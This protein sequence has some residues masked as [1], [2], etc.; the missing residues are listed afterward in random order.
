MAIFHSLI[1]GPLMTTKILVTSTLSQILKF[2]DS[3]KI[4]N[5]LIFKLHYSYNQRNP[6][7]YK[8]IKSVGILP[9]PEIVTN[10]IIIL[11][12]SRNP[13]VTKPFNLSRA[14]ILGRVF[15]L[16]SPTVSLHFQTTS[17]FYS[18]SRSKG[19][20]MNVSLDVNWCPFCPGDLELRSMKSSWFGCFFPN[21]DGISVTHTV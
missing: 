2:T 19:H 16:A 21:K 9:L 4:K 15:R 5:F 12:I 17:S 7:E 6:P 13:E 10:R 1:W 14:S 18:N 3:K 8:I 11:L 20:P